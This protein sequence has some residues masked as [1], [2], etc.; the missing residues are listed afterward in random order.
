MN[1]LPYLA[2][3]GVRPSRRT[4]GENLD[5]FVGGGPRVD[6][7]AG[8]DQCGKYARWVD[9]VLRIEGRVKNERLAAARDGFSGGWVWLR[10]VKNAGW[11]PALRVGW[12]IWASGDAS[13]VGDPGLTI[14]ILPAEASKFNLSK[15][16]T[17]CAAISA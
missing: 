11:Q 17:A 8:W 15:E 10:T 16:I 2:E 6:G 12:P 7:T 4:S 3:T 1:P 5:I 13:R 9:G 14:R